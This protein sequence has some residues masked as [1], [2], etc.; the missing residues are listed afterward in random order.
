MR[1][2]DNYYLLENWPMASRELDYI[3]TVMIRVG[4]VPN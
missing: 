4:L 1:G 3:M 2:P